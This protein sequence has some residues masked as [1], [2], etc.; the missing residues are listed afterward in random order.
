MAL[1][2]PW[3]LAGGGVSGRVADST[4]SVYFEGAEI[5]IVELRRQTTSKK[6]GSFEF[7]DVPAG[8]Y[9]IK[10]DYL[11]AKTLTATVTVKHDQRA[12]IDFEIGGEEALID[13]I[14]VYGQ[15]AGTLSALNRQ[16]S[17][18]G[19]VNV[20]DADAIG[21]F[22]DANVS[23]ALQR[24]PGV[25]IERDQGEG[26]FVGIRGLEPD[27]NSAQINGLSIAAPERDRRSVALDVIPSELIERLEVTKTITPDKDG[28]AIGGIIDVK[29]I[30]AFDRNGTAYKVATTSESSS[31]RGEN[32]PKFSGLWTTLTPTPNGELGIAV[33]GSWQNREFGSENVET[34][35]GWDFDIEDSGFAGAEEIE[36]RDYTITRE[37]LG[38]AINVEHKSNQGNEFYLKTLFSDFADQEYRQR[39]ELKLSDGNLEAIDGNSATWSEIEMDRELKDRYETQRILSALMGGET[40]VDLWTFK[41]SLGISQSTEDEPGRLDIQ[42]SENDEISSAG[43]RSLGEIPEI[44]YSADGREPSNFEL[45]EIVKEDNF[46]EDSERVLKVDVLRNLD[47]GSVPGR[48]QFGT[49][50]RQ[51]TKTDDVNVTVF[52]GGFPGDPTL[53]NFASGIDMDYGLGD[54]GPAIA[55]SR[56]S[57]WVWD[58]IDAF[59]I[60]NDETTLS[61]ARDYEV[62]EDILASYA[63]HRID[64]PPFR[65]VYGLR[66]ERTDSELRGFRSIEDNGDPVVTPVTYSNSYGHVL[67]SAVLRYKN[68]DQAII[69]A[70]FSRTISRASFGHL[71]P[72]PEKIEIDDEDLEIEAGNPNLQPYVSTNFDVSYEFYPSS[73]IG[74]L[75]AGFFYKNIS[76]FIFPADVSSTADVTEWT[77]GLDLSEVEDIEAIQPLN[78]DSASLWGIET[79]VTRRLAGIGAWGERFIMTL[80]GTL[81][82][83]EADLGLGPDADRPTTSAL[84]RQADVVGNV[85]LGYEHDRLSARL[86]AAYKGSRIL[87]IDVGDERGDLLQEP[88]LQ[89]DFTVRY[90]VTDAVQVLFNAKN[91]SES[92]FYAYHGETDFNGQYEEYGRSISIGVSFRSL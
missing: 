16:R 42:F 12:V 85:I 24:V 62:D 50:M 92:K 60:D 35:G 49:A 55:V 75:T 77:G 64:N 71:N 4:E 1:S 79:G 84:P 29:S 86:A 69:R 88:T 10:V 73:Q 54:F 33:S 83:S 61:S 45:D 32:S 47:F 5:E 17:A 59:D 18:D 23:E 20:L 14:I 70:G 3:S 63:M 56:L 9:S 40:D 74:V 43:Y 53:V 51:R 65:L 27:L 66:Y 8:E 28:D 38:L 81:T 37:R 2:A 36:Q 34:D 48:I 15:A 76:D 52:D 39:T 19:L 25:F 90:D 21:Q 78:G 89:V 30:S 6:D 91:L 57:G 26:R 80:N 13:N 82:R 11:G 44:F 87:E 68:S 58:N 7:T 46:T 72:S 31:L 41:Y 22:P 67:P